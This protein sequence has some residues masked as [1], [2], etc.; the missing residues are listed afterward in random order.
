MHYYQHYIL[1]LWRNFDTKMWQEPD[2]PGTY[3]H[4]RH[5]IATRFVEFYYLWTKTVA[6]G[7]TISPHSP[8]VLFSKRLE[9]SWRRLSPRPPPC[10]TSALAC[11][12]AVC[13]KTHLLE[14]Q[15]LLTTLAKSDA[16]GA[17]VLSWS[18]PRIHNI[19]L[20]CCP[21]AISFGLSHSL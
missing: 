14:K 2:G 19:L 11:V 5:S 15:R 16:D 13:M 7:G 8:S 12:W 4:Q 6:S 17:I 1:Y 18:S 3:L 9:V 10:A 20:E 21:L